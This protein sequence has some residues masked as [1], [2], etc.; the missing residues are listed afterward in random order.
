MHRASTTLLTVTLLAAFALGCS[1][2]PSSTDASPSARYYGLMREALCGTMT[3][4]LPAPEMALLQ[5]SLIGEG[6]CAAFVDTAYPNQDASIETALA[7]GTLR[8]DDEAAETCRARMTTGCGQTIDPACM[9]V[10]VGTIPEGGACVMDEECAAG[11]CTGDA[12]ASCGVCIAPTIA[13]GE[14]CDHDREC[15]PS[16]EGSV[17]CRAPQGMFGTVCTLAEEPTVVPSSIGGPCNVPVGDTGY[18]VCGRD[19]YCDAG[20]VCRAP[21]AIGAECSQYDDACEIGAVCSPLPNDATLRCRP[22]RVVGAG[23]PCGATADG[24]AVCD[25]L[26]DLVCDPM[27]SV[28]EEIGDGTQG[29]SC[30]SSFGCEED[31]VCSSSLG[32]IGACTTPFAN[33]QACSTSAACASRYCAIE[34]GSSAGVCA[35]PPVSGACSTP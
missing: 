31:L 17:T 10:L 24:V 27:S 35:E 4:A 20:H 33:G 14:P 12:S 7:R 26:Q 16:T 2:D 9:R 32:G 23:E 3:C 8:F 30:Q 22:I 6:R 25:L 18:A 5:A 34:D 28:C 19:A 13:L 21:R 29:A 11:T 1:S 15:A